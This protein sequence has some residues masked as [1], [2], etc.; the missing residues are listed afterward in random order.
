MISVTSPGFSTELPVDDINE[1]TLVFNANEAKKFSC[2]FEPPKQNDSFEIQI[3]TISLY[4]G[5]EKECCVILR[6]SAAGRENN[7]LDRL[8][9]E[10]QQLRYDYMK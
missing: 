4:L 5:N 7:F 10:I 6:F 3:N 2:N 1:D 9:P 8:Y